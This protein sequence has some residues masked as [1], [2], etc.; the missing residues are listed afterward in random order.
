MCMFFDETFVN[1]RYGLFAIT[2]LGTVTMY[3]QFLDLKFNIDEVKIN[4]TRIP[5]MDATLKNIQRTVHRLKEDLTDS[6]AVIMKLKEELKLY[7]SDKTGL[8]DY[9][10]GGR[11]VVTGATE[12]LET[13]GLALLGVRICG[14]AGLERRL[15]EAATLP[16]DCWPLRGQEGAVTV[17]LL[18][19]VLVTK[20]SLEH[21]ARDLL[22][23]ASLASAPREFSLWGVPDEPADSLHFFG[24]FEY[25]T[26][27]P[28][29]QTFTVP[30]QTP[31]PF[32]V[33]E[34]RVLSN[35]GHPDFTCVYRLRVHGH[36]PV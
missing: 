4:S 28:E 14:Q 8:V 19:T 15:V 33:V 27:G 21:A 13:R 22:P 31:K 29:V 24:K 32:R 11:V 23:E 25:L 2:L 26:S 3:H 34:F 6:R 1:F 16:G 36:P 10:Y 7:K 5:V 17:Q 18:E 9:A 12:S 35:H 20:V 30:N